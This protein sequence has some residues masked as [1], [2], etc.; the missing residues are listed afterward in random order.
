MISQLIT[1]VTSLFLLVTIVNLFTA[2]TIKESASE[3]TDSVVC[4]IPMRNESVHA[5]EVVQSALA[6]TNLHKFQVI[7]LDDH[8]TDSTQ[9]GRAHV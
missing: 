8:S 7:A 5:R 9:I 2:R 6:Q 3:I 4:L 1:V